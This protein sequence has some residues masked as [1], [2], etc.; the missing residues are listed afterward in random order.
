[1]LH[2]GRYREALE[3]ARADTEDS[4]HGKSRLLVLGEVAAFVVTRIGVD[5]QHRHQIIESVFAN[6]PQHTTYVE[7]LRVPA[8]T[9]AL[10][11]NLLWRA[12]EAGGDDEDISE[13][14]FGAIL[15]MAWMALDSTFHWVVAL[16]LAVE[17]GKPDEVLN[18]LADAMFY[19]CR[20]EVDQFVSVLNEQIETE[21]FG[22]LRRIINRRRG[23]PPR[24]IPFTHRMFDDEGNFEVLYTIGIRGKDHD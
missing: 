9:D 15:T 10:D 4:A 20:D 17:L 19:F 2:S 24:T 14:S 11:G 16:H 22:R 5:N 3:I 7:A 13:T 1:L 12:V 21:R 23:A 8:S 6:L 18:A